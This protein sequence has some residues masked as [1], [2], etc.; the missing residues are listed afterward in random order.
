MRQKVPEEFLDELGDPALDTHDRKLTCRWCPES[1]WEWL[2]VG[3]SG[4]S[5]YKLPMGL[6]LDCSK[7]FGSEILEG[8]WSCLVSG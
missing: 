4:L 6:C 2:V 5:V 3:D 1:G 7:V 8:V